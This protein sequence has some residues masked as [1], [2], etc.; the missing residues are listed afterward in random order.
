MA[1][2]LSYG[3]DPLTYLIFS[4]RLDEFLRKLGDE[5]PAAE[6]LVIY[7]P[8]FGRGGRYKT[9]AKSTRKRSEF[10][11][12]DGIV[13]TTIATYL[14]ES[15]WSRSTELKDRELKLREA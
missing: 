12:F 4:T 11:E 10:G 2:I 7:R 1:R 5:T 3:E 13:G 8:S 9:S 14:I 6:A 15:K